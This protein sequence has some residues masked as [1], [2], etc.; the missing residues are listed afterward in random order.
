MVLIIGVRRVERR[1]RGLLGLFDA[2]RARGADQRGARVHVHVGSA[3]EERRCGPRVGV[4]RAGSRWEAPPRPAGGA[5]VEGDRARQALAV[6]RARAQR[7]TARDELRQFV[8]D[9]DRGGRARIGAREDDRP[10]HERGRARVVH[11]EHGR[12]L[13]ETARAHSR[14]PLRPAARDDARCVEFEQTV[15]LDAERAAPRRGIARAP[16]H[17]VHV[18]QTH[19]RGD[20][21]QRRAAAVGDPRAQLEPRHLFARAADAEDLDAG[22]QHEVVC[23]DNAPEHEPRLFR[24]CD[25]DHV[26]AP[27]RLERRARRRVHRGPLRQ[28]RPPLEL[29][30]R[31]VRVAHDDVRATRG[32]ARPERRRRRAE[33]DHSARVRRRGSAPGQSLDRF[34]P[35]AL[36]LGR[37][38]RLRARGIFFARALV[39]AWRVGILRVGSRRDPRENRGGGL[40]SCEDRGGQHA[41]LGESRGKVGIQFWR[42]GEAVCREL[43][44]KLREREREE[45]TSVLVRAQLIGIELCSHQLER[46]AG[47]RVLEQKRAPLEQRA[48]PLGEQRVRSR[49]LAARQSRNVDESVAAQMSK[50]HPVLRQRTLSR[51]NGARRTRRAHLSSLSAPMLIDEVQAGV[52]ALSRFPEF[53]KFGFP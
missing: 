22:V 53:P 27:G 49:E 14:A 5:C 13:A 9:R 37:A 11:R 25:E 26:A 34:Q 24:G 6:V 50:G 7:R 40:L 23:L 36:R 35:L 10:A 31:G 28:Q 15:T 1:R 19:V 12:E 48:G 41:A 46:R 16:Q 29:F 45:R 4:G 17:E 2:H 33:R 39:T 30:G 3:V 32:R 51:T 52:G 20:D 18:G 44:I 47:R 8:R 38:L 43:Y 21:A 42:D